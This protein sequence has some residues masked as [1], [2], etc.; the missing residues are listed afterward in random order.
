MQEEWFARVECRGTVTPAQIER[1]GYTGAQVGDSVSEGRFALELRFD[2]QSTR[3]AVNEALDRAWVA[4]AKAGVEA[5]PAAANVMTLADQQTLPA[6]P[7]LDIVGGA[8]VQEML[9]IN[10]R[11][12]LDQLAH[13]PDFPAPF[14]VLKCGRI[15]LRAGIERFGRTWRRKGEGTPL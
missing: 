14:K 15:W 13:R 10:T 11:Q 6:A 8:E 9:G 7:N 1:L 2:A 5:E 4:L 12:Q 3:H